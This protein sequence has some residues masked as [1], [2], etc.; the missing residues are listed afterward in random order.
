[1]LGCSVMVKT[2]PAAYYNPQFDAD[3]RVRVINYPACA[4]LHSIST[5]PYSVPRILSK[6]DCGPLQRFYSPAVQLEC[7]LG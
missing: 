2:I 3:T 7:C 6:A 5:P 4:A 1:M